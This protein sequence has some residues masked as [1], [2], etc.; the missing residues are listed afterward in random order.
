MTRSPMT[1]AVQIAALI[2]QLLESLRRPAL[3]RF[4][5][6]GRPIP[7]SAQCARPICLCCAGSRT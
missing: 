3:T 4:W 6:I 7:G 5:R 2:K 1:P